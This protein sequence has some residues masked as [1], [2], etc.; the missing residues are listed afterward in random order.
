M[1]LPAEP[2]AEL[3]ACAWPLV[4][5]TAGCRGGYCRVDMNGVIDIPLLLVCANDVDGIDCASVNAVLAWDDDDEPAAA[6]AAD[7]IGIDDDGIA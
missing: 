6:G 2:A 7:V 3:F 5:A 1:C 4:D